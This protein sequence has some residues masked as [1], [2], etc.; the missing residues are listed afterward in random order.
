MAIDVLQELTSCLSNDKKSITIPA[1]LFGGSGPVYDAINQFVQNGKLQLSGP[2][3]STITITGSSNSATVT[4]VGT[5]APFGYTTVTATFTL[6][7][8]SVEID[9]SATIQPGWTLKTAFPD[10]GYPF[11]SLEITQGTLSLTVN[12]GHKPLA[13]VGP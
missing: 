6:N 5:N 10:A 12:V 1:A 2:A 11:S 4:G 9:L 13:L 7:G 3:D 8:S